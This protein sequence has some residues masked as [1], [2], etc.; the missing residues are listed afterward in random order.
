MTRF[1]YVGDDT[2]P[3]DGTLFGHDVKRGAEFDVAPDH[4]THSIVSTHRWFKKVDDAPPP[5][6]APPAKTEP[7]PTDN[8]FEATGGP[9]PAPTPPTPP[10]A[11]KRGKDKE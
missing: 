7:A 10:P 4:P 2:S 8:A 3:D 1:I 11:G 6:P 5:P 9:A